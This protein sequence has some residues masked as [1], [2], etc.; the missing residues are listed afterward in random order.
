MDTLVYRCVRIPEDKEE[1]VL[2]VLGC[3][4]DLRVLVGL[5]HLD[6][7]GDLDDQRDLGDLEVRLSRLGPREHLVVLRGQLDLEG[8]VVREVLWGHRVLEA[9]VIPWV[10]QYPGGQAV[11][12]VAL[13]L[14]VGAGV[15]VDDNMCESR[16]ERMSLGILRHMGWL[17]SCKLNKRNF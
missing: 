7:R 11:V 10:R 16:L 1:V 4:G 17:L 2:V 14:E 5:L 12:L 9:Q 13:V 8:L 3:L 15:V 6:R